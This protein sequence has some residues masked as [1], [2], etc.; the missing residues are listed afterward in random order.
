MSTSREA[1]ELTFHE[2]DIIT[3][4]VSDLHEESNDISWDLKQMMRVWEAGGAL[5]DRVRR[6]PFQRFR[7]LSYVWGSIENPAYIIMNGTTKFWITQNL[8][9][10]LKSLR[11]QNL[12]QS[13]WIDAICINQRDAE[14]K[15]SQIALMRRVYQ[16]AE[17]A[18]AFVPQTLEDTQTLNDLGARILHAGRKCQEVIDSG[19]VIDQREL[20]ENE[21]AAKEGP[22]GEAP[23]SPS[24]SDIDIKEVPLKRTGSCIEDYDLPLEGDSAWIAW[25]KFFASPYF[26]RIWIL[27]EFALARSV[28]FYFGDG[29]APS[30]F[31]LLAMC[32][33][34]DMSRL[35]NAHYL[36]RG[37]DSELGLPALLGWQG[38]ERMTLERI[39]IQAGEKGEKLVDKL[40]SA[41]R[42]D[43]TDPRD[44]IYAL[45]G[46][47]SD[48]E[49]F[50]DLITYDQDQT[51][52]QVYRRFARAFIDNSHITDLLH[53]ACQTPWNSDLPTW[54]PVSV[55]IQ[56]S[57]SLAM[58]TDILKDWSAPT[59]SMTPAISSGHRFYTSGE[60]EVRAT[61]EKDQLV[62][63][64]T[65]FD[66]IGFMSDAFVPFGGDSPYGTGAL[67]L[68]DIFETLA[69]TTNQVC[70]HVNPQDTLSTVSQMFS[71]ITMQPKP[72]DLSQ[73][74]NEPETIKDLTLCHMLLMRVMQYEK[75]VTERIDDHAKHKV[76]FAEFPEEDRDFIQR[77]GENTGARRFCVTK[78]GKRVGLVPG[79]AQVGDHVAVVFGM[80][81]PLVL[82]N[83]I[84][85]DGRGELAD[86][87][88]EVLEEQ[89]QP[90][91]RL[92]GDTYVTGVMQGELLA[93]GK[94]TN[95]GQF[96]VLV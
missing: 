66:T 92:V 70:N 53:M 5:D 95:T 81:V 71:A 62:L 40:P 26:R 60:S 49:A 75:V 55:K 56:R 59:T 37:E 1:L 68:Q 90:K 80:P 43:A 69:I 13:L 52:A 16:Q 77:V 48:A 15:K 25:R 2:D 21:E 8:F 47:A 3:D 86:E 65:T 85:R 76:V 83:V 31:M 96:I 74:T 18:I 72:F 73:P 54:I 27:Q 51:H 6:H 24:E 9:H 11:R 29:H 64:G 20:L 34:R 58:P 44:K 35:L 84:G 61:I 46:L 67:R 19:V 23:S 45:L 88:H 93:E 82:R 94:I 87:R 17:K 79:Q 63:P 32:Y 33:V 39:C 30:D 41:M 14:E 28:D 7:A 22:T 78:A 57:L 10:A 91:Y 89:Q 42:F 36:G 4:S 50:M 12:C 38:L